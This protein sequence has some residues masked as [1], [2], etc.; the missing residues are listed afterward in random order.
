VKG[1]AL[2]VPVYELLGGKCRD[3][4]RTYAPVFSYKAEEMAKECVDLKRRGFTAAR[5]IIPDLSYSGQ[6]NKPIIYSNKILEAIEKVRCCRDAVGYDFDLCI[7]VHRSMTVSEAITFAKGIESL[8]PYF[9]EDPIPPDC[10]EAMVQV[11]GNTS[12]PIAT[13]ERAIN[14]QEF[15]SLLAKQGARY[16]RPDLCAVG[17]ITAAKKIAAL[18]EAHYVGVVPHNPLSLISTA[19]CM[20]IN[21]CIPNFA[22]QELPSF[23]LDGKEDAMFKEK[24]DIEDGHILIPDRPGIGFNLADNIAELF[25]SRPRDLTVG[26]GYDKSIIDR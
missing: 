13:G 10:N 26:I 25:P 4:I 20:Q 23:F 12:I 17:G 9:I 19:A 6:T 11:S 5:L 7:E 16:I 22:I 2:G 1:K 15:E 18:A 3:R 21:A 8:Y 14:I 24:L